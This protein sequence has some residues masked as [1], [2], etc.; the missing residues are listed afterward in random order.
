MMWNFEA[1]PVG[2]NTIKYALYVGNPI[3]IAQKHLK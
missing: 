1:S 3:D 2:M